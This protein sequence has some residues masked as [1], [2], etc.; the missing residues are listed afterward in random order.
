M[1]WYFCFK[2]NIQF[3]MS[4]TQW[5]L[6]KYQFGTHRST[7]YYRTISDDNFIHCTVSCK[8]RWIRASLRNR[9]NWKDDKVSTRNNFEIRAKETT[10]NNFYLKHINDV[11][12]NS[13]N[14]HYQLK[15]WQKY[16][17]MVINCVWNKNYE[18][19]VQ[20]AVQP[21]PQDV[22]IPI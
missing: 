7:T 19:L 10:T 9:K 15:I 14:H 16:L 22:S 5:S 3:I 11:S 21:A 17:I 2:T 20:Q 12:L 6:Y 13:V 1:N 8:S 4:L 18:G